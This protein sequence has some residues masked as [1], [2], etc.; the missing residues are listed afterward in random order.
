MTSTSIHIVRGGK[1]KIG[2]TFTVPFP[3]LYDKVQ[4]NEIAD[5]SCPFDIEIAVP[6]DAENGCESRL[7]GESGCGFKINA[8]RWNDTYFMN[9]VHQN[10]NN[11][12]LTVA[13]AER[14][15]YLKTYAF[16]YSAAWRN[17]LLPVVNVIM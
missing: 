5:M 8:R 2:L 14:K 16:K 1:E 3:C 12:E 9:I 4:S 6:K 15:I 10:T 13:E 17:V 11:Y 7:V